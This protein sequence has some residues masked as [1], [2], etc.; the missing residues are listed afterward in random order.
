MSWGRSRR[1]ARHAADDA[2]VRTTADGGAP[3]G[4]NGLSQTE[5]LLDLAGDGPGD[6]EPGDIESDAAYASAPT[7]AGGTAA[8]VVTETVEDDLPAGVRPPR[9]N[10]TIV[11]VAL[12]AVL[13]LAA[14]IV[15]S[16]LVISPAQRAA[17]VEPPEAGLITVP[18]EQRQLSTD[19]TL[20][21]DALYDDPVSVSLDT[22]EIG[23]AAIVTGQVPEVG[24][25]VDAG[26]V[27]LEVTGRPVIV[28][29]GELPVYRT[30]RMGSSGPDVVQLKEA[31]ASLGYDPGDVS[32]DTFDAATSEAIDSLYSNAGYSSPTADEG[33]EEALAAARETLRM[34]EEGL[35]QAQ[36]ALNQASA[37][38]PQSV[39]LQYDTQVA[40]AER[41]LNAA[42]NAEEPNA[43]EIYQ[44]Q[45]ALEIVRAERSEALAPPDVSGEVAAR[46]AAADAVNDAQAALD[47]A[48]RDARTPLPAS[49]IVYVDSLPRR[50]DSVSIG[51]GDSVSGQVI[52]ISGATLEVTANVSAA[53]VEHLSEGMAVYFTVGEDEIEATITEIGT[54]RGSS[55]EGEG[56]GGSSQSDRRQV[57]I[58]PVEITEEQRARIVGANVRITVPV[59]S[60]GGEVLAVPVA[61]LTA[62]P[63]GESRVEIVRDGEDTELVVVETG[64]AA[65]GYVEITS[66][67][68]NLSPGDLVVVGQ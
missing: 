57:T 2:E 8:A 9:A 64:L 66:S 43:E 28:L 6:T 49:E 59:E 37:G 54:G 68:V 23:G 22:A 25:E 63:G 52:T 12:T 21:G 11:I 47:R 45:E 27:I 55:D 53:D 33:A 3:D 44:A 58:V 48:W 30:L 62:G 35:T 5:Q 46:D 51:Y 24:D 19:L 50:V 16:Q 10:R 38:P 56:S 41:A 40:Q 1:D 4:A 17:E 20:R 65:G 13:S 36:S 7:T 15:L 26:D 39:R 60:T 61:A 32:S 29:P 67:G 42:R 31:L 18:V 14:G 34:A